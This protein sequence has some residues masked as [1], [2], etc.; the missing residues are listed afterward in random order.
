MFNAAPLCD[1]LEIRLDRFDKP[2]EFNVLFEKKFKPAIVACRR[3]SDGGDWQGTE[4]ARL[5]LLR[6][7]IMAQVDYVELEVDVAGDVRRYGPT[8]R[9]V[10]YTNTREVPEDLGEI[11]RECLSKDPDVVKITVPT[12][13]PEEAWPLIKIVA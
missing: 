6:Q 2:P 10:A 7:A 12:R 1:L 9:V 13:T 3:A 4:E 8:K 11:Y 5:V